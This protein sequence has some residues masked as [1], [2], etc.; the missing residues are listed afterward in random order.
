VVRIGV[1]WLRF[2]LVGVSNTVVFAAA[3]LVST[4]AGVHYVAAST[5][6]F[7]LGTLNSYVLNRRWTF[8]SHR[9]RAPELA[10]FLCAQTAGVV[11]SLIL[12]SALVEVGRF[13]HLAAQAVA[14]PI[15]SV[16]TF[17]LSRQ[18]AFAEVRTQRRA[19]RASPNTRLMMRSAKRGWGGSTE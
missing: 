10:R 4:R 6:A 13:H 8:R 9:P 18:W 7:V 14:F 3:Y 19:P 11:A 17:A 16:I 15:A 12:L 2:L 1:E 5:L